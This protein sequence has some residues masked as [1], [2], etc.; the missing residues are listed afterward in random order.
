[1]EMMVAMVSFAALVLAWAFIP[2]KDETAE[3]NAPAMRE[4]TV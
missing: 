3:V 4:V 1:M 2:S